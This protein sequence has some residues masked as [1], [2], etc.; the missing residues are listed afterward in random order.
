[1]PGGSGGVV[2]AV[3]VRERERKRGRDGER[4]GG[5]DIDHNSTLTER[6]VKCTCI[7]LVIGV[8]GSCMGEGM[9]N[10]PLS[11]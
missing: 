3:C 7:S 8:I 11:G 9:T 5:R 6:E 2:V 4:E 10:G 1:M